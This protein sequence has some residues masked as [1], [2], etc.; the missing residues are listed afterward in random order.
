MKKLPAILRRV[1]K[2]AYD[3]TETGSEQVNVADLVIIEYSFVRTGLL[4]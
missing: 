1:R 3:Y 2:Q 4:Q